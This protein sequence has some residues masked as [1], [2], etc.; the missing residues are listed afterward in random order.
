MTQSTTT[1]LSTPHEIFT[2][3]TTTKQTITKQTVPSTQKHTIAEMSTRPEQ[4]S[5]FVTTKLHSTTENSITVRI[6]EGSSIGQTLPSSKPTTILP[7]TISVPTSTNRTEAAQRDQPA[8]AN[9]AAAVT[10]PLCI[11]ILAIIAILVVIF[12]KKR[13]KKF[14]Y[15]Q[16]SFDES[17]IS[18]DQEGS[19]S[20]TNQI[21]D[22]D[23]Q[24]GNS[25]GISDTNNRVNTYKLEVKKNGKALYS[26]GA[27]GKNGLESNAFS[28]P[29]YDATKNLDSPVVEDS[30]YQL[31]LQ[32]EF[33]IQDNTYYYP[34]A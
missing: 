3:Q 23:L 1:K 21:F 20:A 6:S 33:E 25:N 19:V 11:I 5:P 28:N 13:K 8:R 27:A 12:I 15:E 32:E 16:R 29:L 31:P 10:I 4:T 18:Q 34:N 24:P 2:Q 9:V 26:K 17:I 7:A 14:G 22:L 30:Q